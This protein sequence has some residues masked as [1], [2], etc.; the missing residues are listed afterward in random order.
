MLVARNINWSPSLLPAAGGQGRSRSRGEAERRGRDCGG[1]GWGRD[2][3]QLGG[4]SRTEIEVS[5][6]AGNDLYSAPVPWVN[7]W[8]S[9][10]WD[11]TR[12]ITVILPINSLIPKNTNVEC[13]SNFIFFNSIWL[14]LYR[15]VLFTEYLWVR[16][17]DPGLFL[18][19][20]AKSWTRSDKRNLVKAKS[21]KNV[22]KSHL[23]VSIVIICLVS[24]MWRADT[25]IFQ[26]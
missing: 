23:V 6:W 24:V 12:K 17:A 19:L 25:F 22:C 8:A 14:V 20:F 7:C 2:V 21:A 18:S 5:F 26:I 1:R 3:K 10:P 9:E 15:I 4:P 16:L 13:S 11:K